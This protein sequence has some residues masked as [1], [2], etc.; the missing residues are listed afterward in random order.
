[1]CRVEPVFNPWMHPIADL[2][3]TFVVS[4]LCENG[5]KLNESFQ[6][7]QL[8]PNTTVT[9]QIILT[10]AQEASNALAQIK[11]PQQALDDANRE[12]EQLQIQ[13]GY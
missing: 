9:S 6:Y 1:M 13:A 5:Q 7:M 2:V 12:I 4:L 3:L 11:T 8:W 10:L